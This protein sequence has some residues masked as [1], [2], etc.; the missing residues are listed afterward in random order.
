VTT[1]PTQGCADFKQATNGDEYKKHQ[2]AG[3]NMNPELLEGLLVL[4]KTGVII[5]GGCA[6]TLGSIWAMCAA[7]INLFQRRD[8]RDELMPLYEAGRI[9]TKPTILN[10]YRIPGHEL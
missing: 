2:T 8:R 9:T 1:I 10:A 7:A 6:V 3:I 5:G 4:G